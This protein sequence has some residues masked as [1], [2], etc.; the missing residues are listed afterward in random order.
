MIKV[1]LAITFTLFSS[2]NGDNNTY[3]SCDSLAQEC[4][5]LTY[6]DTITDIYEHDQIDLTDTVVIWE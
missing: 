4:L 6:R 3:L 1:M 5:T 2:V